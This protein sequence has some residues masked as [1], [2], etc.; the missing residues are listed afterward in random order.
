MGLCLSCL[1]PA[2]DEEDEFNERSSLLRS[3]D[4]YSDEHLQE[5]LLKKQQRQ[6]ELNNIVNEL[7]DNL[8]DVSTFLSNTTIASN[9]NNSAPNTPNLSMLNYSTSSQEKQYPYLLT[10]KEKDKIAQ[11][12]EQIDSSIKQ[13]CKI[14]VDEPLYLKF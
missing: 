10:S 7:S 1:Y 11:E 8:I 4:F 6:N 14:T 13:S 9:A 5:E 3:Q 2:N 12:V